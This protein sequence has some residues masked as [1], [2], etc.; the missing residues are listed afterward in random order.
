MAN[1]STSSEEQSTLDAFLDR[2]QVVSDELQ[3]SNSE[4]RLT[5]NNPEFNL[6]SFWQTL[7][8]YVQNLSTQTLKLCIVWSKPPYPSGKELN[9]LITPMELTLFGV[10]SSFYSY[11][12]SAG[13]TLYKLIHGNVAITVSNLH[14]FISLTSEIPNKRPT[15]TLII[16]YLCDSS[17]NSKQ[18]A[19]AA[20]K[21]V[22][23]CENLEKMQK[24]NVQACL[25]VIK[26]SKDLCKDA[27]IEAQQAI[28]DN[29]DDGS[30]STWSSKDK[31]IAYAT[32]GL[33]KV[34]TATLN[35]L[36]STIK[37][38]GFSSNE[39][40]NR[41]LDNLTLNTD[42]LSPRL[43]NLVIS[44]YAPVTYENVETCALDLHDCILNILQFTRASYFCKEADMEW[45]S[46][47]EN[48][49]K[50][51]IEKVKTTV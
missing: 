12:R 6:T 26:S 46:F 20:E 48:A 42:Q 50:H 43:D 32:V 28:V 44:L 1:T 38:S 30:G 7:L 25:H 19:Y 24:D 16:A 18:I 23:A 36:S 13:L 49:C 39:S 45:I 34:T 47:L 51:N 40:H 4:P 14:S 37:A 35:K 11:H 41:D 27:L 21:L 33:M 9:E 2:I 3:R 5:T 10:A 8:S 29:G 31:N 15:N 17:N 22:E